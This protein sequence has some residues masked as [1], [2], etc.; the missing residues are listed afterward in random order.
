MRRPKAFDLVHECLSLPN[1][2][3]QPFRKE[4]I[5]ECVVCWKQPAMFSYRTWSRYCC[6]G[7]QFGTSKFHP[8]KALQRV[9]WNTVPSLWSKVHRSRPC[10]IQSLASHTHGNIHKGKNVGPVLIHKEENVAKETQMVDLA[11]TSGSPYLSPIS[12]VEAT[13]W[14]AYFA[15][16]HRGPWCY[17]PRNLLSL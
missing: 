7:S 11:L 6:H 15:T 5:D 9:S 1:R 10:L 3:N 8:M 16:L 2:L 12:M 17:K 14:L 4:V 13:Q